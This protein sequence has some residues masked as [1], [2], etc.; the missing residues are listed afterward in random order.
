MRRIQL[1]TAAL[2]VALVSIDSTAGAR[3]ALLSLPP[4]SSGASDPYC[5]SSYAAAP[6]NRSTP[7][8]FGIDP[9]LAGSAGG[10]QLPSV[11]DNPSRDLGAAR[12]LRP[13]HRALVVR[14][15]RMFW[16]D[17]QAGINRFRRLARSY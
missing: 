2:T 15:N 5:T 11:P 6:A 4:T 16:S 10:A 7:I 13:R 14:L 1:L 12:A 9:G 8:R 3:S 17:G